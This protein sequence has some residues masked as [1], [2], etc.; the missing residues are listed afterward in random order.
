MIR[1]YSSALAIF[2]V[3]V[4]AALYINPSA[5]LSTPAPP[6]PYRLTVSP[7]ANAGAAM[8]ASQISLLG[9]PTHSIKSVNVIGSSSGYHPGR[10]KS[11]SDGTSGSYVTQ[12]HFAE[13]ERV[14]VS[15]SYFTSRAHK[16]QQAHSK[17]WA[18]TVARPVDKQPPRTPK[19]TP[20]KKSNAPFVSVPNLNP[21]PLRVL[22][23]RKQPQPGYLF[24]TPF[25]R[26]GSRYQFGPLLVDNEG[27]LVW[28][29]G[30]QGHPET[31]NCQVQTYL[32]RPVLTWWQGKLDVTS[33]S[34]A[35]KA[36]I[37]NNRYQAIATVRVGNGLRTDLHEFIIGPS[38]SAFISSFARI[39]RDLRCCGGK[40][41]DAVWDSIIQ[42]IDIKSGLVRWEWHALD[43]ISLANS[44]R[45]ADDPPAIKGDTFDP[46]HVNSIEIGGDNS[47]LTSMRHT[48]AVY[49]ID[50]RNGKIQWA[51]G[52]KHSSF[53]LG[54][55]VRFAWQHDA[56]WHAR[57]KS[58]V[59]LFDNQSPPVVL[60]KR[61]SAKLIK[62]DFKSKTARLVRELLSTPRMT[63]PTPSQGNAQFRSTGWTLIGSGHKPFITEYDAAGRVALHAKL[64]K[65]ISSYRALRFPW[66]GRP[67]YPPS[68]AVRTL[69]G[70][71]TVYMSW[72]GATEV[73][74]W[75]I[76]SGEN[77]NTLAPIAT[78]KR[79]GFETTTKLTTAGRV[80][81]AE[82][83]DS[84]GRVLGKSR[85]VRR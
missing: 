11:Y 9:V 54:R 77:S 29:G 57:D 21:P 37:Y 32:G 45:R 41:N 83:L 81:G 17:E 72:N 4:P 68:I 58:I 14:N 65:E 28:F 16:G 47:V 8:P 56:R 25:A 10:L 52:G 15:V 35:G 36:T 73:S 23:S 74:S 20:R 26:N 64:P 50:K 7:Q 62:L 1:S 82:A 51:L 46:Y 63:S 70:T 39:K 30:G 53:K 78:V 69:K 71:T 59:S 33:G 38:G 60:N 55:G 24:L 42:E 79:S 61:S 18:F 19:R 22:S 3:T 85:V 80:V 75:R 6:A 43:N 44:F 27:K 84:Q 31:F 13:G 76:L 5:A 12:R 40:R 34:G 49:N 67:Y 66:V 2:I 48:W